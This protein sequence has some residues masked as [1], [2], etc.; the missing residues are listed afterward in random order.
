MKRW[1]ARTHRIPRDRNPAETRGFLGCSAFVLLHCGRLPARKKKS[2]PLTDFGP[3]LHDRFFLPNPLI[4]DLESVLS[5]L[6]TAGLKLPAAPYQTIWEWQFP[7]LLEWRGLRVRRA[8]KGW[9]LLCETPVEGGTTSRFV[10]TS[11]QRIE[12][13]AGED[14][15]KAYEI[16]VA[17]RHLPLRTASGRGQIA[18]L[19]YRR[20]NLYPSLHPGI[21]PQVPLEVCV[22]EKNPTKSALPSHWPAMPSS[23]NPSRFPAPALLAARCVRLTKAHGPST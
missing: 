18:G 7:L 9:P 8:H 2:R 14:F 10:D 12:F 6:A 21:A 23:S 3:L 15:S 22:L 5:E 1:C 13:F 17:G 11:M 4:W 19:K 20:T 16:Y